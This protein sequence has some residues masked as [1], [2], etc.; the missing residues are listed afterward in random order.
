MKAESL[1]LKHVLFVSFHI[2]CG[3]EKSQ[4]PPPLELCQ[5]PSVYGPDCALV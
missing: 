3:G 5:R 1:P 4:T 2:H